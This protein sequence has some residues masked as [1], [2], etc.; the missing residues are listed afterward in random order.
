VSV[1]ARNLSRELLGVAGVA[2]V[3]GVSDL[4]GLED[5]WIGFGSVGFC[6]IGFCHFIALDWIGSNGVE[7]PGAPVVIPH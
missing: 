1:L 7:A 4:V 5:H 3:G 2:G 6:W